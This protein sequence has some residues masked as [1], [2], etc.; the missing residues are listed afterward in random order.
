MTNT[1]NKALT[2]IPIQKNTKRKL[3][4]LGRKGQSFDKLMSEI[5]THIERCDRFWS[6][7]R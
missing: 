1:K 2:T 6:E 4:L 5:L 7:N 3:T